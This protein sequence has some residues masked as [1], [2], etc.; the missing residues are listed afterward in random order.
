ML[1]CPDYNGIWFVFLCFQSFDKPADDSADKSDGTIV[2]QGF[3]VL[4]VRTKQKIQ[5]LQEAITDLKSLKIDPD[6]DVQVRLIQW[7]VLWKRRGRGRRGKIC[8]PT[9][10]LIMS[11]HACQDYVK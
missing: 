11:I 5:L 2:T 9:A 6:N 8:C 4:E 1:N 3:A 7:I 10:M